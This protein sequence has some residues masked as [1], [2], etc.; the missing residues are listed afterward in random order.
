[1][2]SHA[3][4]RVPDMELAS[5]GIV[6]QAN[7]DKDGKEVFSY[8]T[9]LRSLGFRNNKT[10]SLYA[11]YWNKSGWSDATLVYN[12][13]PLV[14]GG[15]HAP[16]AMYCIDTKNGSYTRVLD[17]R[18]ASPRVP[19][20]RFYLTPKGGQPAVP[21]PPTLVPVADEFFYPVEL[22]ADRTLIHG[23][24]RWVRVDQRD[25]YFRIDYAL[26]DG[27][28]LKHGI[29]RVRVLYFLQPVLPKS[30]AGNSAYQEAT[31]AVGF[32]VNGGSLATYDVPR[33]AL[34]YL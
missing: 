11:Y 12:I 4:S 9:S 26:D 23:G 34:S 14:A 16:E 33:G 20:C 22:P 13:L 6:V 18:G 27:L 31:Y 21:S 28:I 10:F 5:H 25:S 19:S 1:M 17:V 2:E 29:S 8:H 15:L 7:L 30:L 24:C 3:F 32:D